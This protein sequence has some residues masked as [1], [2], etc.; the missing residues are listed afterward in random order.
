MRIWTVSTQALYLFTVLL[1]LQLSFQVSGAERVQRSVITFYD[2]Q[3]DDPRWGLVHQRAELPLNHLGLNLHY[4]DLRQ[5]LPDITKMNDLLGVFLWFEQGGIPNPELF[6]EWLNRAMDSGKKLVFFGDIAWLNNEQEEPVAESISRTFWERVQ[7]TPHQGW[8]SITFDDQV[9]QEDADI[10]GFEHPLIRPFP[11]YQRLQPLNPDRVDSHLILKNRQGV[12]GHLALTAPW[13]G[14]VAYGYAKYQ[15]RQAFEL[16]QWI[17]NPFLFFS[18]AFGLEHS[19]IPDS[20]TLTGR[21]IYYS[22][23][24]GDGWRNVPKMPEQE[25][26]GLLSSEVILNEVI[27]NYPDLPVTVGIIGADIDLNWFG[28]EQTR[29]IARDTLLEEHVE[30]ASHTMSHPLQWDFFRDYSVEKELPYQTLYEKPRTITGRGVARLFGLEEPE[31]AAYDTAQKPSEQLDS[32]EIPRAYGVEPFT[33]KKELIDAVDLV[34]QLA[35]TGKQVNIMQWSGNTAPFADALKMVSD[36]GINNIN[37]G[38]ARFDGEYPSYTWVS[39]LVRQVDGLLQIYTSNSNENTYTNLWTE[40]FFGF[41]LLRRTLDNT[42]RPL[43][44]KPIN[45]YYHSYSGERL[46]SL[47]ALKRNLDY[48]RKL[49]ITP[50]TTSHFASIVEGSIKAEFYRQGK[51][52]W[53]VKNHHPLAT[54]RFDRASMLGVDF[55]RSEGVIGQRHYQGSLYTRDL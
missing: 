52:R 38:D 27:R 37:G 55:S 50:V 42:D 19:P 22:H 4:H 49:E 10:F 5:P 21:R 41:Q 26:L 1:F 24:D 35:P 47:L 18:R 23:I 16:T 9:V 25:K 43:R 31:R 12:E 28:T 34:N 2:S 44:I 40:R 36:L 54:I 15:H 20:N 17:V 7:L 8:Q 46:S 32:Y 6:I 29:R 30:A 53:Q 51:L 39:P 33:L 14:Y 11:P 45:V 48:V 13:G 3:Q